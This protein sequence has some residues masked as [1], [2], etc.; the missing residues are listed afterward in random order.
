VV[1]CIINFSGLTHSQYRVGLPRPGRWREVIN[2]DAY[3]YGGSGAGNMGAV[4]ATEREWHGLPA[5][6]EL[7]VP[8]LGAIWLVPE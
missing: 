2:T 1:A 6:A 3:V 4:E 5:S 7:T 8:P